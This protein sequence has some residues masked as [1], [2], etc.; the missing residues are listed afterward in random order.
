MYGSYDQQGT[1]AFFGET[2]APDSPHATE[3]LLGVFRGSLREAIEIAV[4]IPRFVS[5]GGGGRISAVEVY[6]EKF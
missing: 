6:G 1:W 2:D 5:W 3:P 4:T